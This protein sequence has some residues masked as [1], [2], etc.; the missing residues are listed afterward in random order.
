MS[1]KDIDPKLELHIRKEHDKFRDESDEKYAIKLVERIVFGLVSL[2]LTG[3]IVAWL[4]LII[5]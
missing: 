4:A 5:R 3:A 1:E 2:I